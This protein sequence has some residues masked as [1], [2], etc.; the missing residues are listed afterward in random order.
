MIN[1]LQGQLVAL[2]G[3]PHDAAAI[4]ARFQELGRAV[5]AAG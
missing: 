5:L 2:F 3:M 4:V 1:G